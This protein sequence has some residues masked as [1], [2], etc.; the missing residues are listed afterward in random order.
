MQ[1]GAGAGMPLRGLHFAAPLSSASCGILA[2]VRDDAPVND[3]RAGAAPEGGR[4]LELVLSYA[5][6]ELSVVGCYAPDRRSQRPAFMEQVLGPALPRGR[7]C[8]PKKTHRTAGSGNPIRPR[9]LAMHPNAR[10]L[11]CHPWP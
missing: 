1:D 4:V 2:L 6:R 8:G 3:V 9:S 10:R 7:P 11:A 5:G